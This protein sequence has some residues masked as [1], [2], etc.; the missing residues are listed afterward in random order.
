MGKQTNAFQRLCAYL[1][2]QFH[3]PATVEESAFLPDKY[4]GELK[5]ID[6]LV[7]VPVEGYSMSN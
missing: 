2:E 5:E 4:T 3:S 7:A 6:V 1:Q